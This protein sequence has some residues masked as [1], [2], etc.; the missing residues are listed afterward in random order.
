MG[1]MAKARLRELDPMGRSSP[2]MVSL[3]L[4]RVFCTY[5]YIDCNAISCSP[6]LDIDS[7]A[8]K[9]TT[10][11]GTTSSSTSPHIREGAKGD[12]QRKISKYYDDATVSQ[13]KSKEVLEILQNAEN[14]RECENHLVLLL[15]YDCFELIK[16]LMKNRDMITYC[17]RLKMAQND[18]EREKIM[19]DMRKSSHLRRILNQLEGMY[20]LKCNMF[21]NQNFVPMT[22]ILLKICNPYFLLRFFF[23]GKLFD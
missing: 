23:F 10:I 15:G 14:D 6:R 11:H 1:E 17:I 9:V 16:I 8:L 18:D 3:N 13:K 20:L 2:D 19:S 7:L 5:L 22:F 4:A 21:K 12:P